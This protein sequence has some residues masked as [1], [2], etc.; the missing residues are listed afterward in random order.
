VQM[1]GWLKKE[2]KTVKDLVGLRFAVSGYAA[3]VLERL[4]GKPANLPIGEIFDNLQ[5]GNIDGAEW[6]GPYN[7]LSLGL[8]KLTKNYYWPG[9]QEPGCGIE[10][11]VNRRKYDALADDLKQIVAAACTAEN[12]ISQAEY[13]GRNPGALA[14]LM[15]EYK[16][17]LK[18]YPK[19]VLAAFASAAG[20]TMQE[21]FDKGDDGTRKIGSSY[22]KFRKQAI[23]WTRIA[24]DAFA[25][26]RD[27][28]YDY[29]TG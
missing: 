6:I 14:T 7:D 22:F 24:Y 29:P 8:Y 15:N 20:K 21:I 12:A 23:A 4:G 10:A 19:P 16:V 5:S 11:L 25:G 18:Q 9:V 28:K 13:S 1:G 27:G 26:A 17:Q 3:Q 2:I